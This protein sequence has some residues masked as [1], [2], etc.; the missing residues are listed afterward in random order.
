[1]VSKYLSFVSMVFLQLEKRHHSQLDECV[2]PLY[3]LFDYSAQLAAN[4]YFH[5]LDWSRCDRCKSCSKGQRPHQT[6]Y[7]PFC[8]TQ[9][10]PLHHTGVRS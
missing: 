2:H 7:D 1:M 8:S 9:G 6:A 3:Y 4:C 10:L 5:P